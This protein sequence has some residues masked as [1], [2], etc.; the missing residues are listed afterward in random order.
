[1]NNTTIGDINAIVG[2]PSG[3]GTGS[4]KVQ[5]IVAAILEDV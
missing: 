5:C 1:M 3:G 4:D 2:D